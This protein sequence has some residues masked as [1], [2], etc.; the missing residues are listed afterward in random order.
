MIV[1]KGQSIFD[2][3]MM[4][5]GSL[6]E[7]FTMLNENGLTLN[8]KLVAGQEITATTT[9]LGDEDIKNFVILKDIPYNNSQSDGL[10]PL[11]EGD[12]NVD[13]NGDYL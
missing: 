6:E 11:F 5:F 4:L 1:D 12:Y 3:N 2:V 9:N 8:S 7:L 13:Y 10:P